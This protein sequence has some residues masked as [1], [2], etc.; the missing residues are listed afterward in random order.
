M[1]FPILCLEKFVQDTCRPFPDW[2]DFLRRAAQTKFRQGLQVRGARM[3]F[4][5][6]SPV[7]CT[8]E[9]VPGNA[10]LSDN[11]GWSRALYL[12]WADSSAAS[13]L[14]SCSSASGK[15][16]LKRSLARRPEKSRMTEVTNPAPTSTKQTGTLALAQILNPKP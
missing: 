14:G 5:E 10:L 12:T 7:L 11:A 16:S 3:G 9:V 13:V 2:A 8:D 15:A 1:S 4:V 6:L